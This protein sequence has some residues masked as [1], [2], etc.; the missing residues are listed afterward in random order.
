MLKK[1][2]KIIFFTGLLVAVDI[3]LI[4]FSFILAYWV[5]FSIKIVP[6]TKGTPSLFAYQQALPFVILIWI[7]IFMHYGL[8]N[9]KKRKDSFDE[10]LRS[11]LAVSIGTIVIMAGTFLYRNFSYSRM[12]IAYAWLFSLFSL[13]F[14]RWIVRILEKSLDKNFFTSQ[15]TLIMGE[16][17]IFDQ[18]KK[19][20]EKQKSEY[21]FTDL[22]E[23][24][25]LS[26]FVEKNKIAEVIVGKF[27]TVHTEI[28]NISRQCENL[29][30]DFKFV[31]DLVE[32]RM[33]EVIIDDYLGLPLIQLKPI[34]LHGINFFIKRC[35]D[36][37]IS[38]LVLS[39]FFV[40]LLIIIIM[41]KLD[42]PGPILYCQPRL[43]HKEKM[44]PFFK[45]R[46]M[47]Q[48]ADLIL[49]KI[50]HLSERQGPVFKMK[51]D[52]R[53]T[54]CGKILRRY[55]L[56]E[57]PQ[58]INVLRGDMS[59]VGPRPQVLWEAS[60]Y[61]EWAKKRLRVLPGITGL[62]QIS[63]RSD[64]SYE[65]MIRLDIFYL[66]NW[67]FIFDLKILLKTIPVVLLADGAY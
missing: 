52:P 37:L 14:S 24:E 59:L 17:K 1:R 5:R 63:G 67:S 65:E 8:Y 20:L 48:D 16:G 44:F 57:L 49:E 2:E 46:T 25:K 62:W 50:K 53:I 51:K 4:Y 23:G 32:L 22:I 28:L 13:S 66:E 6:V 18:L 19:I 26:N 43:G 11:F 30:L 55:S 7:L 35:L 60:H 21:Y 45:F 33:G 12:V 3:I 41:I 29:N 15:K 56:D 9:Y 42:T 47:V 40:P 38:I 54:F 58:V 34:S 39:I 61:D 31:P 10:F 27:P 36:I 64:L